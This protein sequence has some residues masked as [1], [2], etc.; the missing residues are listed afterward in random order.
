MIELTSADPGEWAGYAH[1]ELGLLVACGRW[2]KG[3]VKTKVLAIELPRIYPLGKSKANPND[4]VQL[5][6]R[7]GRIAEHYDENHTSWYHPQQWKGQVPDKIL[8]GQEGEPGRIVKLLTNT[9]KVIVK[10]SLDNIAPGYR[11]NVLD[12]IGIGLYHIGRAGR[13]MVP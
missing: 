6:I 2:Y 3:L 5:S 10:L 12:A 1:W 9:E 13:G 7:A 4:I 11:H 8:Y